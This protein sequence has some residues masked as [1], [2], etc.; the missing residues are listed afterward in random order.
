M[1]IGYVL[2]A[3]VFLFA[4]STLFYALSYFV[5]EASKIEVPKPS[6]V[7]VAGEPNLWKQVSALSSSLSSYVLVAAGALI[8]ASFIWQRRR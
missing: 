4:M 6:N 2:L 3:L 1:Q 5:Q 8:L 7:T